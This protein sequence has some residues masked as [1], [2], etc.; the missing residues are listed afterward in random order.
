MK[1][2]KM[3]RRLVTILLIVFVQIVGMGLILP[4]LPLYTQRQFNMSPEAISLL[5]ASFFIAQFIA[6]PFLGRLSDKYGRLPVLIVSQIGTAI[7]FVMLGLA[8]SV[9]MLF[10]ARIFDGIT[11]GNIIVAQAYVT[12]ITPPERRAQSLGLIFAAF[13]VGFA[14]GPAMGGVLSALFGP[15][16]PFFFA[17]LVA[18]ATVFLTWFT[19]DETLSPEQR[20]T[21]RNFK[22]AGLT[23]NQVLRNSTL[24]L[25]LLIAFSGQFLMGMIQSTFALYGEAVLLVGYSPE[26]VNLGV[27]LLLTVVGLSQLFVQILLLP[28]MLDRFGEAKLVIIGTLIRSVAMF[29]FAVAAMLWMGVLASML[30]PL[31]MG[32]MMPPLQS[33]ATRTVAD[34]LRG[35]ILG[36]YQSTMSLAIIFGTSLGGIFFAMGPTLPFWIGGGLG[37]LIV[38]PSVVL[39]QKTIG[40]SMDEDTILASG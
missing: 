2:K 13:G 36:L 15:K 6:G 24:L 8:E 26:M 14:V 25:I 17:A 37:I 1:S 20:E 12:D 10:I 28:R 27:G 32:L 16:I 4:I 33:L 22:K 30:L 11:G 31:G 3:D 29:T 38:L 23:P 9:T 7:S 21:N 34:E 19:L 40:L 35:G 5:I 18:L 39:W